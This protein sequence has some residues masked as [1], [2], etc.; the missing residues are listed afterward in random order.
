MKIEEIRHGWEKSPK[1]CRFG[2]CPW[3]ED[4]DR[5]RERERT[6]NEKG[7]GR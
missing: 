7:K 1:L 4:R 6:V 2:A 3:I 5:D